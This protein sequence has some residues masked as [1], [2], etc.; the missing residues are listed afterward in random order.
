MKTTGAE[1]IIDYL[2]RQGVE[3]IAG[4]Q[5]HGCVNIFD[6]IRD[7]E[8]KGLI[9]YIQ[10]KQEMSAVHLADGYYRACGKPAAILTSIGPGAF[11]TGIGVATA[12]VDSIPLIV[13][14]GDTHVNMRGTG[15]LQ[16]IE[17]NHDSDY[18]STMRPIAKRA[19][20]AENVQQL[21]SIMRRAYN[22]M[23]SGR[24][25]PV[26]LSLPMD[27]QADTMEYDVQKEPIQQPCRE[28]K[29][30]DSAIDQA[31]ALLKAAKRP[32]MILG[33]GVLYSRQ[34]E[35]VIKLA[36]A[37][38]APVVTTMAGKG[39]FP[40]THPLYAWHT[41]SRGTDVGNHLT[42]T[43]DVVLALGCRFSD[44]TTSSY[45]KGI[46]FNFP[47]TKLIQVDID[48][49]EIGKNYAADVGILGDAN[50]VAKQLLE[51][52]E[53]DGITDYTTTEYFAEIQQEKAKWTAR[54]DAFAAEDNGVM[55]IL[56]IARLLDKIY[57]ENG[58]IATSSGSS[59]VQIFQSYNFKMTGRH[60][61]TGG[62]STMGWSMP[63]AQGVAIADPDAPVLSFTGDGDFLMT[64]QEMSTSVQYQLPVITMVLNNSGWMAIK[65]LQ[66]SAYGTDEMTYANDFKDY[67]GDR[68]MVDYV[69]LAEGFGMQAKRCYTLDEVKAAMEE[70][71]ALRKPYLIEAMVDNSF[72][73]GDGV[74]TGWWDMP[75]P[76]YAEATYENYV[77]GK[78]EEFAQ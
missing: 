75:V 48:T 51:R 39:A 10:V 7:R 12:Y 38:G 63:A 21:P 20:R 62:F 29:A 47:D 50:S 30:V 64:M 42:R 71:I 34:Y 57:P 5:G 68:Y 28:L 40:E 36:E 54:C 56:Q 3:L 70:A 22:E 27:V 17:R 58:Y 60:I 8:Q 77:E 18:I 35:N 53:A 6:I 69:K 78:K 26:V 14:S 43:A 44:Q 76:Y 59:Q 2:I 16:E 41:G 15:V 4:V 72:P 9:R 1:I 11:N 49:G 55:T 73:Y 33:G 52:Y 37:I 23:M 46:S 67:Q 19:W 65:A 45:R 32:V 61:T 25:G 31:Y 66:I 13:L 74:S 24:R